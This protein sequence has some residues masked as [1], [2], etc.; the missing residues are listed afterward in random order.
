MKKY[1][2]L[3]TISVFL[4]AACD[5][6]SEDTQED[7][8]PALPF[9]QNDIADVDTSL[10]PII[11]I[12]RTGTAVADTTFVKREEFRG[13]AAEFLQIPDLSQKEYKKRFTEEKF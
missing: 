3:F 6:K 12:T 5:Q 10:Y 13:L 9:I 4:I 2:L 1:L 11:K 7:F 8:L